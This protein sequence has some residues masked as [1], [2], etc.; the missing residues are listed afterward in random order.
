MM[1]EIPAINLL[2]FTL[3]TTQRHVSFFRAR[4]HIAQ[5][6][7]SLRLIVQTQRQFG[8]HASFDDKRRKKS[9]NVSMFR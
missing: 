1:V 5:V 8:E 4:P 7:R 3:E 9:C 6:L 2:V